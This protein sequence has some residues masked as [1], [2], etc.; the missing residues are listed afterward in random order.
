MLLYANLASVNAVNIICRWFEMIFHKYSWTSLNVIERDKKIR[1][2]YN[3]FTYK[4]T[5]NDCKLGD[6]FQ[7]NGQFA[8]ADTR[9]CRLKDRI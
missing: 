8:I 9:S 2:E 7:K 3:E 4:K 6:K 1:L 5:K